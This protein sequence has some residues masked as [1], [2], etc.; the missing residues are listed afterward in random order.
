[1][2]K[3]ASV[4]NISLFHLLSRPLLECRMKGNVKFLYRHFL[5]QADI[6]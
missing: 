6:P 3:P 4:K 1:V 5:Y 2:Y